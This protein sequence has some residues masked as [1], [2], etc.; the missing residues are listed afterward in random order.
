[1]TPLHEHCQI[2]DTQ[3]PIVLTQTVTLYLVNNYIIT[4]WPI[5]TGTIFSKKATVETP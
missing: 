5:M 3:N 4:V 1:M 2:F